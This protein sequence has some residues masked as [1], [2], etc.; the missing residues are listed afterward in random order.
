MCCWQLLS[1]ASFL[2]IRLQTIQQRSVDMNTKLMNTGVH[3]NVTDM[4]MDMYT[5]NLKIVTKA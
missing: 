5:E 4:I 1:R 3:V 2:I